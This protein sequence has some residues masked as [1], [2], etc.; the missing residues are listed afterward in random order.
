PGLSVERR[1]HGLGVHADL[2]ER[3]GVGVG[4]DE[5]GEERAD[6]GG[7]AALLVPGLAFD[8]VGDLPASERLVLVGLAA[9]D[10]A[11]PV[12][13][14][15]RRQ[16]SSASSRLRAAGVVHATFSST[17]YSPFFASASLEVARK[18][19]VRAPR[20]GVRRANLARRSA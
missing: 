20:S 13:S 3:L 12:M 9:P 11:T 16:S 6:R 1:G 2:A 18:M 4:L 14:S 19:P 7:G 5:A 15:L 8:L 17:Q 10:H